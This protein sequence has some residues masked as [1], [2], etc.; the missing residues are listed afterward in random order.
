MSMDSLEIT[1][2][3]GLSSTE[4]QR[5]LAWFSRQSEARRIEIL[6]KKHSIF[7]SLSQ[8]YSATREGQ[9]LDYCSILIACKEP[10]L[11]SIK[12]RSKREMTEADHKLL[13]IEIK[14]KALSLKQT[15]KGKKRESL[16]KH[17][18]TIVRLK[19]D[20]GLGFGKIAEYLQKYHRIKVSRGYLH[21]YWISKMENEIDN[22]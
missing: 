22:K 2:V 5:V 9:V 19:K 10:W 18:A 4:R 13:S 15:K 11:A 3:T 17:W 14:T 21:Q 8:K 16:A 7:K 20:D 1:L 12:L 6:G